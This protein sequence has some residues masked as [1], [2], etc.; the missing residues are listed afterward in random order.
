MRDGFVSP[1]LS[2]AQLQL[3]SVPGPSLVLD[4]RSAPG[5]ALAFSAVGDGGGRLLEG[6]DRRFALRSL[7]RGLLGPDLAFGHLRVFV[8][9]LAF[10][11]S[12]IQG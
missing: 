4:C 12:T 10:Q 1:D 8:R 9:E 2:D 6:S 7:G 3:S 5:E 11:L